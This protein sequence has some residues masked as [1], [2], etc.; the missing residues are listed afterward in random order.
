MFP[1]GAQQPARGSLKVMSAT[2]PDQLHK[3][4]QLG[5][6]LWS[7]KGAQQISTVPC[8]HA[9]TDWESGCV[10]V[11]RWIYEFNQTFHN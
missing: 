3:T 6:S 4:I 8:E 5:K 2:P 1:A 9:S 10:S 7:P 11:L